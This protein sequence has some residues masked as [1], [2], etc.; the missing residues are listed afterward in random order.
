MKTAGE[1]NINNIAN[2]AKIKAENIDISMYFL[3]LTDNALSAGLLTEH[4][5]EDMQSQIYDMLSDSIWMFTNGTSA[6]VKSKEANELLLAVLA[7]IDC[8]CISYMSETDVNANTAVTELIE[9]LKLKG[10]VRNCYNKG[11]KVVE[12]LLA[13][14]KI[15]AK[16][17]YANRIFVNS[18]LYNKTISQG[19]FV[20]ADKYKYLSAHRIDANIDYPTALNIIRLRGVLYMK[21][22]LSFIN[23]E[24]KFCAKCIDYFG[25][26]EIDRLIKT[27][28][29]NNFTSD[30]KLMDNI[31]VI[32]FANVFFS[33]MANLL[34]EK[35]LVL[36]KKEFEQISGVIY[37]TTGED[38]AKAVNK[39][40]INLFL[41]LKINGE[42]IDLKNYISDY[43]NIF[44]KNLFE[45]V[46]SRELDKFITIAGG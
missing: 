43:T 15:L 3:S 46:K 21:T 29:H 44:V 5:I 11:L 34:E 25:K 2:I 24:N 40:V 32:I 38:F 17:V 41:T 6:S 33:F 20:F 22:Y 26:A 16:E 37:N 13:E 36:N 45:A 19:I 14:V 7:V 31:F 23:S 42:D 27:Y 39:T 10:G 28:S 12:K 8:F 1:N 9:M 35:K 4:D 18:E 30:I